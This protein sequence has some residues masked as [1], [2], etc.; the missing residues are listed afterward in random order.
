MDQHQLGFATS[1]RLAKTLFQRPLISVE[2]SP[3]LETKADDGLA[4]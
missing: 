3:V 4:T 1:I 2:S